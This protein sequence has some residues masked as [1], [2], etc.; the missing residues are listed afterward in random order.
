MALVHSRMALVHSRM[1]LVH[2]RMALIHSRMALVLLVGESSFGLS[3]FLSARLGKGAIGGVALHRA[4]DGVAPHRA[5]LSG[6]SK[7]RS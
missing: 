6:G 1:A 4:I 3:R 5:S 7:V 2:S